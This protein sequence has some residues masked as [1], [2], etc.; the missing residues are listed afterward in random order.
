MNQ[1]CAHRCL[2]NAMIKSPNDNESPLLGS[3]I[4]VGDMDDN[5]F[6]PSAILLD[7]AGQR[8]KKIVS[9][10]VLIKQIPD[11][12]AG[13]RY[14]RHVIQLHSWICT[15][16]KRVGWTEQLMMDDDR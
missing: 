15:P 12:I 13:A 11:G 8:P 3:N 1:S 14:R 2:L 4:N 16:R 10:I 7:S 5:G 6:F 9:W